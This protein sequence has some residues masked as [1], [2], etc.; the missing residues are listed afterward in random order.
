MNESI[1]KGNKCGESGCGYFIYST[2]SVTMVN[3]LADSNES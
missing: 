3:I 1:F 2:D